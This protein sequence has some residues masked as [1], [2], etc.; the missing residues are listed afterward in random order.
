MRSLQFPK[1]FNINNTNVHNSSNYDTSTRQNLMLLL[2]SCRGT[3]LGDPYFGNNLE[4]YLFEQNNY[5]L[6][7]I[8]ID[9][10]YTQIVSFIPQ[11]KVERRDIDV[12]Q[13][14]VRGQ[15]IIRITGVSMIDFKVHTYSL[16]MLQNSTI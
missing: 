14:A 7:D 16:N 4:Q 6:K 10:I 2:E 1:M 3:L 15:L 5:V 11:L 8:V 12:I 9:L 13:D